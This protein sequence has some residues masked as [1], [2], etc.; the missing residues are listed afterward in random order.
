MTAIVSADDQTLLL[1][2][3]AAGTF[4]G[5]SLKLAVG[6]SEFLSPFTEKLFG[7]KVLF[8]PASL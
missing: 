1:S 7:K 4:F 5:T 8:Q 2:M 6:L 3:E